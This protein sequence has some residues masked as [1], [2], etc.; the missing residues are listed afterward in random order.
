LTVASLT[1]SVVAIS[2][3]ERPPASG[4]RTLV[5]APGETD[6]VEGASDALVRL[7]LAGGRDDVEVLAAREVVV[8][9]RFL[10][11]RADAGECFGPSGGHR[12]TEDADLA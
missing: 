8:E 7:R 6:A 3:F 1:T 2:A 10:D 5:G 4:R 12:V 11:D 9:A